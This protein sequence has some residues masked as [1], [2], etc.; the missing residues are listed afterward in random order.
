MLIFRW[1][2]LLLLLAAGVSFAFF[3]ATGQQR[4]KRFGLVIVKWTVIA[5]SMFFLVL[6]LERLL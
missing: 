3:A 1:A 6:I 5:A 4:Y 2:V